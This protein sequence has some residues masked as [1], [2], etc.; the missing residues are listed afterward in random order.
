M[1]QTRHWCH[2]GWGESHRERETAVGCGGWRWHDGHG[3]NFT[4]IRWRRRFFPLSWSVDIKAASVTRSDGS[5]IFGP[6]DLSQRQMKNQTR[7]VCS[8][9]TSPWLA[10]LLP[11]K[12]HTHRAYRHVYGFCASLTATDRVHQRQRQNQLPSRP[13]QLGPPQKK[14]EKKK[15]DS[16]FIRLR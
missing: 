2:C 10:A 14:I 7:H 16:K 11:P 3:R 13:L 5:V 12:T 1:Q 8:R 4:N 15:F 9:A 6:L